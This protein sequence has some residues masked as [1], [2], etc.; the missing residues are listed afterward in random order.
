MTD[1]PVA[2]SLVAVPNEVPGSIGIS[3]GLIPE[4]EPHDAVERRIAFY[5]TDTP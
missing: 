3:F 4:V 1:A 2:V 5:K